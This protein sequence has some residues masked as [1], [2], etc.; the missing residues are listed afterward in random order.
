MRPG[1]E[2]DVISLDEEAIL[3][4]PA[5][6]GGMKKEMEQLAAGVLDCA[7]QAASA[8]E[9]LERRVYE[10]KLAV[11]GDL[12]EGNR[13]GRR[14]KNSP[15]GEIPEEWDVVHLG[16]IV[17]RE[18]GIVK[19]P[20][21]NTLSAADA[22]AGVPV[23]TAQSIARLRL[24]PGKCRHVPDGFEKTG[25]FGVYACDIVLA[26]RGEHAGLSAIMPLSFAGGI[27]APECVKISVDRSR[28][29]P[30]FLNNLLHY[31]YR[32]GILDSCRL[33]SE[34]RP[35][36]LDFLK[37]MLLPLP[38]LEEQKRIAGTLLS[39]SAGIAEIEECR[40]R[41]EKI[42]AS[43]SPPANAIPDIRGGV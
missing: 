42:R 5:R 22:P 10:Y 25:D 13:G 1:P 23:I 4:F 9:E 17:R 19:G 40:N 35:I 24:E 7:G 16:E 27:L 6:E 36:G 33:Q 2:R 31:Y 32:K 28:M 12:L 18:G 21:E 26:V 11:M 38:P 8:L 43:Y 30:F 34:E 15:L 41:I 3:H 14:R 29:E 39:I 37:K 20:L